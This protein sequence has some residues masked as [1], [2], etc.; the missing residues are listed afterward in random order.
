V[1]FRFGVP[2]V[3]DLERANRPVT[4][5]STV[6]YSFADLSSGELA[7]GQTISLDLTKP[8]HR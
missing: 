7:P 3:A 5:T 6:W 4:G 2:E 8:I 1:A